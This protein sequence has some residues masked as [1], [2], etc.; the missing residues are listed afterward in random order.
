MNG[1]GGMRLTS[2]TLYALR[3]LVYLARHGGKE[4]VAG[5]VIARAEGLS[6]RFLPK[7]LV[8]LMGAGVLHSARARSGGYRLARPPK[9][10]TLL[11]VVE[12]VDGPVRGEAPPV[13]VTPEGRRLD[14]RLQAVCDKAA[15][16][17][18]ERLRRVS[19]ADLANGA[20]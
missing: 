1:R 19:L 15:D 16:V 18:R 2:A 6:A 13:G 20:G 4:P 10:I 14:S 17:T 11:E 7:A 3:A 9:S 5:H 12:A 8:S